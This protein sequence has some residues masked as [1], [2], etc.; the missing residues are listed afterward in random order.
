M[1]L[2]ISRRINVVGLAVVAGIVLLWQVLVV[3]GVLDFQYLPAPTEV[4]VALVELVQQGA[5]LEDLVHTLLVV[6]QAW[7]IA[8]VIGGIVGVAVAQ[9]RWLD[10]LTRTSIDVL[11]SLPVVA[12]VPVVL[13]IV[14]P[15]RESEVIVAAYAATWPMIINV[16]GA[17]RQIPPRLYE[18]ATTFRLNWFATARKIVLPAV[19]PSVVVGARLAMGLSLVVTIVAEMIGNPEGL[20]YGL[21]QWQFALRPDAMWAY[22]VVI[23]T[24]GLVLNG[25]LVMVARLLPSA[26]AEV[27]R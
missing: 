19:L 11:R 10:S 16:S 12:F 17:I 27:P 14:G 25:V 21:V 18:V 7:I 9:V 23:A 6:I 1:A 2:R 26:T 3:T 5:L 8:V 20:G 15:T 22:L 4:A 24:L 13:M